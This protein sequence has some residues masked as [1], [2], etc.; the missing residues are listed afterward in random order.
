MKKT[1]LYIFLIILSNPVAYTQVFEDTITL[2]R[3][4]GGYK[5]F[6][7]G[8]RLSMSEVVD[9][10]EDNYDAHVQLKAAS[11]NY[12]LSNMF[13]VVGGLMMM[14]PPVSTLAGGE[15]LWLL[16]GIGAGLVIAAIPISKLAARQEK[17]AI[18]MY[19]RQLK[20]PDLKPEAKIQLSKTTYGFG[21][22]LLF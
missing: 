20:E 9:I 16:A 4:F 14:Y 17:E 21:I 7:Y 3:V 22:V 12:R 13:G 18:T 5:Y 6:Q 19:N 15:P 11:V 1:F 8:N 2:E 10:L